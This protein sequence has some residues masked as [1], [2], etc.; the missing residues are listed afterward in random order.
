MRAFSEAAR[1]H[2]DV[3]GPPL[4]GF[5][6]EIPRHLI[7][8]RPYFMSDVMLLTG[9]D[10]GTGEEQKQGGASRRSERRSWKGAGGG[11]LRN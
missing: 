5:T 10:G 7:R 3:D 1:K 6:R 8:G 9:H 11:T 2:S 4:G